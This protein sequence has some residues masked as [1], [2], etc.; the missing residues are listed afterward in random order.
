MIE[1]Y[2]I[3][4]EYIKNF[5]S[6]NKTDKKFFNLINKIKNEQM[7]LFKK[8]NGNKEDY[9]GYKHNWDYAYHMKCESVIKEEAI[10]LSK[11]LNLTYYFE[12]DA[13]G[14]QFYII[15]KDGI[16]IGDNV[17]YFH[18]KEL[19]LSQQESFLYFLVKYKEN[20]EKNK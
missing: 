5:F 11:E 19:D 16:S 13:M 18:D 6:K 4:E 15:Y 7:V 9:T 20:L 10:K 3:I 2:N 8:E 14:A 1:I 17:K 12:D